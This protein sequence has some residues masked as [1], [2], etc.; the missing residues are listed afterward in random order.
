MCT[1]VTVRGNPTTTP[2]P[3]LLSILINSSI[4]DSPIN[5]M[6]I[7]TGALIRQ[8]ASFNFAKFVHATLNFVGVTGNHQQSYHLENCR[9]AY[10]LYDKNDHMT[11]SN[12]GFH[13]RVSQDTM[14]NFT[15]ELTD[16]VLLQIN[17]TLEKHNDKLLHPVIKAILKKLDIDDII[18]IDGCEIA[19]RESSRDK[20]PNKGV[21]RNKA[22][23]SSAVPSI[24]GHAA[25]SLIRHNFTSIDFTEAVENEREHLN[26]EL[27]ARK[28]IVG[29]RGYISEDLEEELLS[30]HADFIIKGKKNMTSGIIVE[31]YGD[32]NRKLDDFIGKNYGNIKTA[33]NDQELDVTVKTKK[34]HLVRIVRQVNPNTKSTRK[35]KDDTNVNEDSYVYLR[36]SITR[37]RLTL[38][39]LFAGYR[40]RWGCE[41]LFEAL[42][43]GNCFKSI[44]SS[45]M[46][47]I[48]TFI[49]MNIISFLLKLYMTLQ[50][51]IDS[52]KNLCSFSI[53]KTNTKFEVFN[54]FFGSFGFLK[55][56]QFYLV[57]KRTKEK[58]LQYCCI[59]HVSKRDIK[60]GKS[61]AVLF[62]SILN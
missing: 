39:E 3:S 47:V 50:T 12:K 11:I 35:G 48:F 44:N 19:L 7:A 6:A 32:N 1:L 49:L 58:I 27:L 16:Q 62:D 34:G 8:G 26:P 51:S 59:S 52:K 33:C 17:K 42:Q 30:N 24:K 28:C 55:K 56:T 15:I 29:D 57:M 5:E 18:A 41:F 9:V 38:K 61:N 37:D 2:I 14:L 21:G 45:N 10:N 46:N 60:A 43:Q 4:D 54:E 31:A 13:K 36:T 23:G 25:Y 22:D 20:F 53:L 40:L